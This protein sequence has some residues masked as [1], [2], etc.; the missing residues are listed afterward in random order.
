MKKYIPFIL[1]L[2]IEIFFVVSA[3]F[4]YTYLGQD[5]SLTYVVYNLALFILANIYFVNDLRCNRFK[6]S[7]RNLY[8]LIMVLII[9]I[10]FLIEYLLGHVSDVIFE[11][12]QFFVLWSFP[13]ILMGIYLSKK[14]RY[15]D[16]IYFFDIFLI[17]SNIAL[18]NTLINSI[19]NNTIVSIGGANYQQAGYIFAFSFGINL[20]L[21][22]FG[23]N[24]KRFRYSSTNWYSNAS[25][26]FLILQ[27]IGVIISGARGAMVLI[28]VYSIFISIKLI[29]H[30]SSLIKLFVIISSV[31]IV[32]Y[33]NWPKL[34][35][36]P[37][38]A[39]SWGRVFA[40]ITRD[41]IN[42]AGTSG[43]DI[44][45]GDA[46]ILIKQSPLFGHGFFG[47]WDKLGF[48][49]HNIIL[50]VLLQGGIIYLMFFLLAMIFLVRKVY[51]LGKKDTYYEAYSILLIY[52]LVMLM[53]SGSYIYNNVLWFI[54]SM[55]VSTIFK[56][57]KIIQHKKVGQDHESV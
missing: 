43:R 45:Y 36:I 41:G 21:I 50:E 13:S 57:T 46:I 15:R 44:L 40:Y 38:I 37:I 11:R 27:I 48:S 17:F 22:I 26:I 33:L 12:F 20:F 55:S 51:K 52:P 23:K 54:F 35:K 9:A 7:I 28:I 3:A 18:I 2:S 42:W 5:S 16:I 56:D 1:I 31:I 25:K 8:L 24:F 49:P 47:Y 10:I 39:K 32:I 30:P 29:R 34:I 6:I 4:K 14:E 19:S 53:F